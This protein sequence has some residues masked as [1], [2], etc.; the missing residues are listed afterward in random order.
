MATWMSGSSSILS[1]PVAS[2]SLYTVGEGGMMRICVYK[3][4]VGVMVVDSLYVFPFLP[5]YPPTNPTQPTRLDPPARRVAAEVRLDARAGGVLQQ[6]GQ[7]P[8][9]PP[10]L[11]C[12][13]G[14]L[15]G[16]WGD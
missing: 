1:A 6:I 16:C 12:N 7:L 11:L 8:V 15:L 5:P 14:G 2:R 13:V 3:F 9:L 4:G 10:H